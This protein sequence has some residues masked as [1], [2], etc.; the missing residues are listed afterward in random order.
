MSIRVQCA[1]KNGTFSETLIT[2]EFG[3]DYDNICLFIGDGSTNYPVPVFVSVP[4][5]S[6]SAGEPIQMAVDAN[7]LYI[8][9]ASGTWRRIAHA[10]W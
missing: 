1:I 9:R 4:S 6:G 10:T 7:Y 2:G 3:F 5:T 8:C